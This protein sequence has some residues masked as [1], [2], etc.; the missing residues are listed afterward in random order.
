[1]KNGVMMQYFEWNLPNDGN[2]WKQLKADAAH[3]HE[4]G[5][6]AVWIPPAY[7]ARKQDDEGYGIYD[8]YDLGEFNQK[9]TIRTKYG[10]RQELQEMIEELHKNQINVYLDA[11]MNHKAGADYTEKF[12]AK[13]VNPDQREE[14]IS[15]PYEIEGWTG[16]NFPGRKGK[17]SDFKNLRAQYS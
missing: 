12:M 10:T 14:D 16:F 8:L 4:V 5:V 2:L 9:E 13:E 11:V 17:Y 7:K 3:L 6:T 1:M 15:E